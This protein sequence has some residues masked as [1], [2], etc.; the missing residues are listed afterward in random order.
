MIG[1][2]SPGAPAPP[3]LRLPTPVSDLTAVRTDG[4][5]RLDWTMPTRTTDRMALKHP[6][7]ARI[8]RKVEGG[9]CTV[10]STVSS[11]PGKPAHYTDVL[12]ADLTHGSVRLLS[13]EVDLLNYAQKSAGRSAPAFT[14]AGASPA[15]VTGLTAQVQRDGVLLSWHPAIESPASGPPPPPTSMLF[16]ITRVR[17]NVP[18]MQATASRSAEKPA[19]AVQLLAVHSSAAVD[20]GHALDHDAALNQQY[21][22]TVERVAS[23]HLSGHIVEVQ[24]QPSDPVVIA[25]TDVF[26]PAVPQDLAAVADEAGGAIDLSWTPDTDGDLAGYAVYRRDVAA[27]LPAQRISSASL[28][29]PDFRDTGAQRGHTYAYSV[30]AI[31]TSGNESARSG[32]AVET[33]PNQ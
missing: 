26:P 12:P 4:S 8:C 11:D 32:E 31:D 1:C 33:L 29:T 20:P 27:G 18:A 30:S 21:R 14:A 15:T 28:A 9:Q 17:Q 5:V 2:G 23:F 6:V 24:G 7:Q 19:P 22:Y 25:T 10:V 3:S 16:R 13:Y